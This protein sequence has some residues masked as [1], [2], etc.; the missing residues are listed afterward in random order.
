MQEGIIC[1]LFMH[2]NSKLKAKE[3]G[4]KTAMY[5]KSIKNKDGKQM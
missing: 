4:M 5:H 2:T 3:L 1:S